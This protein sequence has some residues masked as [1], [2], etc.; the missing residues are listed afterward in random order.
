MDTVTTLV[1]PWAAGTTSPTRG[2]HYAS[3]DAATTD[4][5]D[6]GRCVAGAF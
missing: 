2:M 3:A 1:E 4:L 6:E 5:I